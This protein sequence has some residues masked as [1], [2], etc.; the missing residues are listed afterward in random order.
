MSLK[1]GVNLLSDNFLAPCISGGQPKTLGMKEK[2][3]KK[4]SPPFE[5][6]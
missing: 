5:L 6:I 4:V 3:Y 1:P 2:L